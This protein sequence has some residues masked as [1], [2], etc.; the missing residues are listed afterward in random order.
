MGI[1]SDASISTFSI[2]WR[3]TSAARES[4]RRQVR[5]LSTGFRKVE[6]DAETFQRLVVMLKLR[7][8]RSLPKGV[9]NDDVY[10]KL[11]K[12]IPRMDLE[13]LLPGTQ[14]KMSLFDRTKIV[15][16]T[17]SGMAMTGWKLIT[18]AMV[19][20]ASGIYNTLALAG[21][22]GGTISYGLRSF[23]GYCKPSSAIN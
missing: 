10:L 12:D 21:L 9:D 14:I 20:A 23:H 13:M 11:F 6:S 5:R 22:A 8:H 2:A 16:P 7:P 18:G 19:V 4:K 17:L 15:L 3:S 1:E